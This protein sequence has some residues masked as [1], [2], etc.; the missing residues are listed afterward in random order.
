LHIIIS[1]KQSDLEVFFD[2]TKLDKQL[3]VSSF[4]D[5]SLKMILTSFA[6]DRSLNIILLGNLGIGKSIFQAYL[7]YR[8][9]QGRDD[10]TLPLKPEV[11]IRH[12]SGKQPAFEVYV[13]RSGSVYTATD[14]SVTAQNKARF[15]RGKILR[16][17]EPKPDKS[18]PPTTV[19]VLTLSTLS[20]YPPRVKEIEKQSTQT[21]DMPVWTKPEFIALGR[22]YHRMLPQGNVK[23][24]DESVAER[25]ERYGAMIRCIAVE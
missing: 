25:F 19:N 12:I 15:A 21:L 24:D 22:Y 18:P 6:V 9:I 1:T 17:Y 16:L 14:L 4:Y 13:L 11:I 8:L 10:P 2:E 7:L 20:L 3:F 23:Y 5:A